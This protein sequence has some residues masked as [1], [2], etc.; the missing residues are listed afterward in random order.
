MADI[1]F[2]HRGTEIDPH[3]GMISVWASIGLMS[4]MDLFELFPW[5]V[6]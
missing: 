1:D 2:S 6:A 4:K 5:L 3:H